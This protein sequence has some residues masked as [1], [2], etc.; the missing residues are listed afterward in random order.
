MEIISSLHQ[1]LKVKVALFGNV[2]VRKK[3]WMC[4]KD[5]IHYCNDIF[6]FHARNNLDFIPSPS[7]IRH[8]IHGYKMPLY[9]IN[10]FHH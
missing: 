7:S 3:S 6:D 10:Y 4:L 8:K 1:A 2:F 9:I 5:G